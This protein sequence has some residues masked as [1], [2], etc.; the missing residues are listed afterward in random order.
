MRGRSPTVTKALGTGIGSALVND[1]VLVPN[2]ELGHI[3]ID[4]QDAE[5]NV[6]TAARAAR[7]GLEAGGQAPAGLL[8]EARVEEPD[9]SRGLSSVN[10]PPGQYT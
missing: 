1:G 3:E 8:R 2:T 9:S 10:N 6:S 7:V 4:G 5:K